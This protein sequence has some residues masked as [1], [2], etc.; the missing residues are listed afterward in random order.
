MVLL[1]T[2]LHDI[3]CPVVFIE[4]SASLPDFLG[5]AIAEIGEHYERTLLPD[6]SLY[7]YTA[8]ASNLED[9]VK[10]LASS[11]VTAKY[12]I[13]FA[14]DLVRTLAELPAP[15]KALAHHLKTGVNS[16]KPVELKKQD[17][18]FKS[19]LPSRRLNTLELAEKN[20]TA[21]ILSE[22]IIVSTE[23]SFSGDKKVRAMLFLFSLRDWKS[24]I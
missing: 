8:S 3:A 17:P 23:G 7:K 4:H 21:F 18:V 15:R 16:K 1:A 2:P 9:E 14:G 22:P 19:L 10:A 20:G 5:D 11:E 24:S 13:N 6:F 12:S